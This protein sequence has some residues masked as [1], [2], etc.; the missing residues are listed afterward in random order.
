MA[1]ERIT[2]FQACAIALAHQAVYPKGAS[3]PA[4]EATRSIIKHLGYV[5]IDTISVVERAHHHVLWSRNRRYCPSHLK[6]LQDE[7]K[8]FEYWAHA[9]AYLPIEDYRMYLPDMQRIRDRCGLWHKA[10]PKIKRHV[11]ARI[12][13]EGPLRSRDFSDHDGG[14]KEM[15]HW[16]PAKV[17]LE[18]LFREGELMV[19]RREGFEKVFDLRERVLPDWVDTRFPS[20]QEHADFLIDRY[21]SA[22]GLGTAFE[23]T[24]L[25][26][27]V[28]SVVERRL[29]ELEE[30]E[31][32]IKLQVG[33]KIYH[34]KADL[35]EH[36]SAFRRHCQARLL[37]PFDNLLI[38][39][40]RLQALF[41]FDY[42]LECYMPESK[43]RYGYFCLPVLWNNRLVARIDCKADRKSRAFLIRNL[44]FEPDFRISE[45]FRTSLNAELKAFMRFN[46]CVRLQFDG[47][48]NAEVASML[49]IGGGKN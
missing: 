14:S 47:A 16:K 46:Q 44:I 27:G 19:V 36:S 29:F 5:Q 1:P 45:R 7:T 20:L 49:E 10:N 11:L 18:T 6:I 26:T 31:Q 34:A 12:R 35:M 40:R 30:S 37:S 17:A 23:M 8:I 21:L 32:L 3:Q 39:R 15:W 43:R 38:Q 22:N 33:D 48:L 24:Y 25:R 13:D 2:A 4:L 42:Q 9:A 28:R 41:D